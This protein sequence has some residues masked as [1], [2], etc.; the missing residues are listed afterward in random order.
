MVNDSHLIRLTV[1]DANAVLVRLAHVRI[2]ALG[3]I[4]G[5]LRLHTERLFRSSLASWAGYW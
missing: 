3:W 4:W 1:P 2:M 5:Y